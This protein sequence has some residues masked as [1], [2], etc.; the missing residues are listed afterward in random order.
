GLHQYSLIDTLRAA[1]A[2]AGNALLAGAIVV[3]SQQPSRRRYGV[4]RAMGRSAAAPA[5]PSST[6]PAPYPDT[7][8]GRRLLS[9]RR[10][11]IGHARPGKPGRALVRRPHQ[12]Q[13]AVPFG[14]A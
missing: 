3:A 9:G 2:S 12:A 8:A 14:A 7:R 13:V 4:L 5:K 1:P 10:R 11:A 6:F